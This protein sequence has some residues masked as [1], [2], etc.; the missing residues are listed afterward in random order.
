MKGRGSP[1]V[2]ALSLSGDIQWVF[3]SDKSYYYGKPNG[4]A[5][6]AESSGRCGFPNQ[7]SIP[8]PEFK[9]RSG[10]CA[11][12][13][14]SDGTVYAG[15][16]DALYA[17]GT[18]AASSVV[19]NK[20]DVQLQVGEHETLIAAV[21]PAEAT[22]KQLDWSSSNNEVASVDDAGV[23]TA[24]SPGNAV[25]TATVKDGGFIATSVITVR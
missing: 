19:L 14:G 4:A 10:W 18:T 23:V 11:P 8:N 9:G 24:L 1:S 21:T 17:L 13:V 20:Q 15:S 22:N 12:A 7:R 6:T 25:I 2:Y 3:A 16:G 5:A